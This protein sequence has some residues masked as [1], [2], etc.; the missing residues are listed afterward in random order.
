MGMVDVG[1]GIGL[2][3]GGIFTG[4]MFDVFGNY[5]LAYWVASAMALLS[6]VAVWGVKLV[7]GKQ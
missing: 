7:E 2:A 3:T 1:R 5:A 4:V 6:I